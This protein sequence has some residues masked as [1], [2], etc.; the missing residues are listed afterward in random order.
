[1]KGET[2]SNGQP[3]MLIKGIASTASVDS[4]GESLDPRGFDLSNFKWINWNHQGKDNPAAII[5]EPTKA[6]ITKANELY[7]EGELFEDM[8]MAK[9]VWQLMNS[10]AK[11]SSK[12]GNLCLSVEGKVL[13]RNPNDHNHVTKSAL[14]AVAICPTPINGDTWVGL[15]QKGYTENNDWQSNKEVE[16]EI[17]KTITTETTAP[18]TKESKVLTKSEIYE[19]IFKQYPDIELPQAKEVYNLINQI[20]EMKKSDITV[21]TLKKAYDILELAKS[22]DADADDKAKKDKKK[23]KDNDDSDDDGDEGAEEKMV[24][25]AVAAVAVLRDNGVEDDSII[26]AAL[27]KKEFTDEVITKALA[28][29][30]NVLVPGY[31]FE[32]AFKRLS[33]Q[34]EKSDTTTQTKFSAMAEIFKA[35]NGA[36]E[37]MSEMLE[38]STSIIEG[39]GE[40]IKTL[41]D[42]PLAPKSKM[43]ISYQERFAK[44]AD[45]KDKAKYNLLNKSDR[46]ALK[47]A[48]SAKADLVKATDSR[49]WERIMRIGSNLEVSQRITP[50]DAQLL[51]S[52]DIEVLVGA[53][54]EA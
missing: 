18:I 13:E 51:K 15:L 16:D 50:E 3:K 6:E 49:Q 33:G 22:A 53:E 21:D 37:E 17:E 24:E 31:D 41:E 29:K 48:I 8:P 43:G 9:A 47:G 4:Q 1:M 54:A 46:N 11:S 12:K 19:S 38:K 32:K 36:I 23:N 35:Q 2:G 44:S 10:F 45:A 27:V 52:L 34:I 39:L 25:K 42:T 40:R 28:V 20:S 14:T 30:T 5:G 26:K 7:I